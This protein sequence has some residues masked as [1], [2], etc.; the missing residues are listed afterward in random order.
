MADDVREFTKQE[1]LQPGEGSFYRSREV[2]FAAGPFQDVKVG[3]KK[4]SDP[5]FVVVDDAQSNNDSKIHWMDADEFHEKY[6]PASQAE[7]PYN[8]GPHFDAHEASKE[9]AE[10]YQMDDKV[11]GDLEAG[12]RLQDVR[13]TGS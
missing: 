13:G 4:Q 1:H 8:P 12:Q 10:G 7:L 6:A 3:G 2:I 11:K 5:G 9:Q